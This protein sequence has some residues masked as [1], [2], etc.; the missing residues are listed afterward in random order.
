M[1]RLLEM[2]LRVDIFTL[3]ADNREGVAGGVLHKSWPAILL[4]K[5]FRHGCFPANFAKF[6]KTTIL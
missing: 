5:R 2:S 6:L 1:L 3:F 4:K